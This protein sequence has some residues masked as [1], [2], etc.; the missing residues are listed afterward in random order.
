M[1]M[2]SPITNAVPNMLYILLA[3]GIFNAVLVPQLVGTHQHDHDGGEF[4]PCPRTLDTECVRLRG[5]GEGSRE[6]VLVGV[7]G[8]LAAW[9]RAD[10]RGGLAACSASTHDRDVSETRRFDPL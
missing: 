5:F 3:G 10:A 9:R 4:G 2:F 6:L 8:Q 1:P 7:R